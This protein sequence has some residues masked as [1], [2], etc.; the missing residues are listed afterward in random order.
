M[1]VT[2]DG[3]EQVLN[4]PYASAKV[5]RAGNVETSTTSRPDVQQVFG[6]ALA[7]MPVRPASFTVYFDEGSD[8]LTPQSRGVV[9]RIFAEIARR[10]APEVVVIGHTDAVGTMAYNDEL[11]IKRA[12]RMRDELVKLG[13]AKDR[14]RMAGRG[15]RE[16]LIRTPDGAPQP[17]NRRVE[18]TVR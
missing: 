16:P 9:A 7:A 3:K 14:I 17:R 11:S 15:K 12:E 1:S 6:P 8:E 18:V 13:A 4:Q 10:Q 2:S 5:E